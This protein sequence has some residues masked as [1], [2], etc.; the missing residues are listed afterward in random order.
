MPDKEIAAR[1]P[2]VADSTPVHELLFT[3]QK[4][5]IAAIVSP[6][7]AAKLER[8]QIESIKGRATLDVEAYWINVECGV[9]YY[10]VKFRSLSGLMTAEL[11]PDSI[12]AS[13]C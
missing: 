4:D 11:K 6:V 10:G 9:E 2:R 1:L 13:H 7:D 5:F 3:N 12:P 8:R